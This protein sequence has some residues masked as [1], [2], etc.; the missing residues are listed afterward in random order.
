MSFSKLLYYFERRKKKGKEEGIYFLFL[1][2][3]EYVPNAE[4]NSTMVM[5]TTVAVEN[6]LTVDVVGSVTL[7]CWSMNVACTAQAFAVTLYG[8]GLVV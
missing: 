4:S 5:I 1:R 3:Y 6:S 7:L 2:V 8:S